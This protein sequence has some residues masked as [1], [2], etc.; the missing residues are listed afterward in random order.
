[1]TFEAPLAPERAGAGSNGER[2][3]RD[4]RRLATQLRRQLGSRDA[5]RLAELLEPEVR[6]TPT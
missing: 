6:E 4:I 3:A 1:M 2:D 5:A